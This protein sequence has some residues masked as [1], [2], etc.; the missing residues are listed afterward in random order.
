MIEKRK[1]TNGRERGAV[2]ISRRVR[3]H[4]PDLW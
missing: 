3:L 2:R 4:E 1:V